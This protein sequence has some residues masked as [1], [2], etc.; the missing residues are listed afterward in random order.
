MSGGATASR[1]VAWGDRAC[2]VH[3]D[4]SPRAR[5]LVGAGGTAPARAVTY[6]PSAAR[7][8]LTLHPGAVADADLNWSNWCHGDL[9]PLRVRLTLPVGA[10][11]VESSFDGPPNVPGCTA[12]G[13]PSTLWE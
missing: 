9:G 3:G 13:Q 12:P 8:V 11:T 1:P 5:S 7:T 10:G 2:G 6:Q 4:G